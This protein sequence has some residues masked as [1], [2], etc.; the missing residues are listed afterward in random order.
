MTTEAVRKRAAEIAHRV[1]P[2]M[3]SE[4]PLDPHGRTI[5]VEH[6]ANIIANELDMALAMAVKRIEELE[7][8]LAMA[9]RF[10]WPE[11]KDL[12]FRVAIESRGDGKWAII[13]GGMCWTRDGEWEY[14][15][16]P[17][18]RTDEFIARTRYTLEE[19][20]KLAPAAQAS[21][22]DRS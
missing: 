7:A 15:S 10:D 22:D 12:H 20:F 21:V 5:A 2:G 19:A 14:E 18:N 1:I 3:H 13:N 4:Y 17:S 6:A 9:V 16:M 8:R 11:Y